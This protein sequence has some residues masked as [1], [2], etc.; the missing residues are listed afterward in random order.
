MEKNEKILK[1]DL[2][3]KIG[4]VIFNMYGDPKK[5]ILIDT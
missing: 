3:S 5:A 1:K 4:Y 2:Q